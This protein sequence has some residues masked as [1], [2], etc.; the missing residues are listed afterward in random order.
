MEKA[1]R[2]TDIFLGDFGNPWDYVLAARDMRHLVNGT[3]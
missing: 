2:K 1:G 3:E